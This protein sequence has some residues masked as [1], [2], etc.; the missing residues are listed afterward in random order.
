MSLRVLTL[1]GLC[2]LVSPAAA[3]TWSL[4]AT[5]A[6]FLGSDADAGAGRVVAVGDL[7]G[8]G[9]PDIGIGAPFDDA[10]G[11]DAGRVYLFSGA[12]VLHRNLLPDEADAVIAGADPGALL[13]WSLAGA[14]DLDGDGHRDLAVGAPLQRTG[15]GSGTV[16]VFFGPMDDWDLPLQVADADVIV[17]A[18]HL[19]S[20]L[21]ATL[22]GGGDVTGDGLDDLWLGAP[23]TSD[24]ED[25]PL[26]V[27]LDEHKLGRVHLLAGDP[28][29]PPLVELGVYAHLSLAG[30]TPAGMF[31]SSLAAGEDISG[32]GVP[33]LCVGSPNAEAYGLDAAG[34]VHCF[35]VVRAMPAGDHLADAARFVVYGP[36]EDGLAGTSLDLADFDGDGV[37]DL[38]IGAPYVQTLLTDGGS[39][40]GFA[41]GTGLPVGDRSWDSG[42]FN[43]RGMEVSGCFGYEVLGA[44]DLTGNGFHDLLLAAPGAADAGFVTGLVYMLPGRPQGGEWPE[45]ATD[46]SIV[47]EGEFDLDRAGTHLAAIGPMG[48]PP[49]GFLVGSIHSGH[50]GHEAGKVWLLHLAVDVDDDGDGYT[51]LDGDCRDADDESYP[52]ADADPDRDDDCDGWTE[53]QGDCDD[54]CANCFPGGPEIADELDNDCDGEVD[55]AADPS[56]DDDG[57]GWT[58]ADGDC[59]DADAEVFPGAD[60]DCDGVDDNCN[61]VVDDDMCGDDDAA[62]DDDDDDTAEPA[63]DDTADDD[64]CS[65]SAAGAPRAT[66]LIPLSAI[67]AL[68]LRR[69]RGR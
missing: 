45:A 2:A 8:D 33:D 5:P 59:D 52:G 11:L 18:E 24:T 26:E 21:G 67:G 42:V 9:V 13:G 60:E 37:H 12:R 32:D 15:D 66:S 16:F 50:A 48:G 56:P 44:G 62:D 63:D 69:R 19:S 30:E 53:G 46:L 20:G 49:A 23:Y 35:T 1:A 31:G 51:E 29:L 61:G 3:Q 6:S 27:E 25:D 7:D 34:T 55:E 68:L 39:V 54:D 58:V 10:D 14:G 36:D 43:V 4:S 38:V 40:A 57:D 65:C 22:A 47:M 64:D 41:G 17:Q 28:S